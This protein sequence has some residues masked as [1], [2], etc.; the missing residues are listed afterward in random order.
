[1]GQGTLAGGEMGW[2][3]D[4]EDSSGSQAGKRRGGYEWNHLAKSGGCGWEGAK[5]LWVM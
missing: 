1:M 5:E 2:K 4:W 3:P